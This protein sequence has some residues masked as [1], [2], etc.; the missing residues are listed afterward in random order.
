MSITLNNIHYDPGRYK[1]RSTG[2][3]WKRARLV[4]SYDN[5]H[6]KNDEA[7]II[8]PFHRLVGKATKKSRE[9]LANTLP[10]TLPDLM[11]EDLATWFEAAGLDLLPEEEKQL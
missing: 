8:D 2:Y 11:D 5:G 7:D 1:S 3:E 4:V 6:G 10:F 9:A